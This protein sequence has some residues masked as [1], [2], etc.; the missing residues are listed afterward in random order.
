MG[1]FTVR[2]FK[3]VTPDELQ[4]KV[5]ANLALYEPDTVGRKIAVDLIHGHGCSMIEFGYLN[6]EGEVFRSVG[7]QL[8][9]I[10]MDVRYQDGDWWDISVYEGAE[11]LCTHSVNPWAHER[12]VNYSQEHI[13]WRIDRVCKLWPVPGK[14]MRPYLLLWREP[15]RRLGC[16]RYVA[17]KGKAYP[18][19]SYSYGNADQ[20]H[21]FLRLF[22]SDK[23]S[24]RVTIGP[25]A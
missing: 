7:Y 14:R 6:R 22:G 17:R 8:G 25:L 4:R 20:I 11:H 23:L 19:D 9:C 10:W 16:T 2:I 15:V 18:T 12:R 5:L 21:D 24:T 13:D 1:Y 3:G